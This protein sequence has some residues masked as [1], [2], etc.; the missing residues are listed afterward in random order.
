M[1][2]PLTAASTL[3]ERRPFRQ[4][5]ELKKDAEKLALS[6]KSAQGPQVDLARTGRT[7]DA[8]CL[9]QAMGICEKA[10]CGCMVS[11]FFW[12]KSCLPWKF[13]NEDISTCSHMFDAKGDLL[14]RNG[15][16]GGSG[17]CFWGGD[18]EG[19]GFSSPSPRQMSQGPSQPH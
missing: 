18:R 10:P 8:T 11:F 6:A 9:A 2:H 12:G 3:P 13:T 1:E 7:L 17:P 16:S 5:P 19:L 14:S 4:I 15:L